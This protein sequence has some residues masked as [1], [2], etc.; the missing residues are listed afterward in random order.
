[1]R[2]IS[3]FFLQTNYIST[4]YFSVS[5]QFNKVIPSMSLLATISPRENVCWKSYN[6]RNTITNTVAVWNTITEYCRR[7]LP[8]KTIAVWIISRNYT[9]LH[10]WI[11]FSRK[12]I[13]RIF[14]VIVIWNF[15][16]YW[17]RFFAWSEFFDKELISVLFNFN[18]PVFSLNDMTTEHY[19]RK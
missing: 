4:I 19:S 14:R 5:V 6:S 9:E 13:F 16:F 8:L 3:L 11:L 18:L 10:G 15:S 7:I 2:H 12:F 1:M 17:V